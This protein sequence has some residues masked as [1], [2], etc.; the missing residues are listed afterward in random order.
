MSRF[1]E[2][3]VREALV[4]ACRLAAMP[5]RRSPAFVKATTEG[6]VRPPSVLGITTERP[7]SIK[8][9]QE[10]VVPRSI[11]ISLDI[12]FSS[13]IVNSHA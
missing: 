7:F 5:T 10:L 3:N 13:E 1:T 11:P 6:V 8:A 9:T 4:T 2:E 12:G